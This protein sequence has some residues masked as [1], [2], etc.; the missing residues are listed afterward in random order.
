MHISFTWIFRWLGVSCIA[1]GTAAGLFWIGKRD[2]EWSLR[3]TV[4]GK[5][6][7]ASGCALSALSILYMETYCMVTELLLGCFAGSLLAAAV[8]DLW[9]QMVYRFVWW[10][11]GGVAAVLLSMQFGRGEAAEGIAVQLALYI[12]L[13]QAVFAHFYGRADCH[14]F[15]VCAVCMAA[16]GMDFSD[17]T[18]HMVLTFAGLTT[19]ALASGNVTCGGRLKRPVPLVPY[20][21]T[22]FWICGSFPALG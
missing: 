11:A 18:V 13:Q 8:M 19:V 5:W 12:I 21:V 10:I 7:L 15:S 2:V 6:I 3:L 17:F 22:A 1:G 14:A 16:L 9:E 4:R 20:I